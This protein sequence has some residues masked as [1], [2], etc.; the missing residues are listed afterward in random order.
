MKKA[1]RILLCV[2]AMTLFASSCTKSARNTIIISGEWELVHV[3]TYDAANYATPID[4]YRPGD[5]G[6]RTYYD[7][8]D[9][10]QLVCTDVSSMGLGETISRGT[11]FVDGSTLV[12]TF[13]TGKVTYHVDTANLTDLILFRDYE[14]LGKNYHEVTTFKKY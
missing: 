6:M 13:A 4:T 7:F 14:K 1:I 8:V 12:M 3:H 5:L 2:L 10:G 11:W 9:G